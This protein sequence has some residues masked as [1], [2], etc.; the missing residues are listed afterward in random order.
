MEGWKRGRTRTFPRTGDQTIQLSSAW[1]MESS[2]PPGCPTSKPGSRHTSAITASHIF[3]EGIPPTIV[4]FKAQA[5]EKKSQK[6]RSWKTMDVK[7][8]HGSGDAG[9]LADSKARASLYN[10]YL[11]NRL[12]ASPHP[13][14]LPSPFL[15]HSLGAH[16]IYPPCPPP[17]P[18][19]P[20]IRIY[21]Q[22]ALIQNPTRALVMYSIQNPSKDSSC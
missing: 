17:P 20:P 18:F 7:L 3:S 21:Q 6:P 10:L 5:V 12:A 11:C 13:P 4:S 9:T 1:L 15:S 16:F 19:T 22:S 8:G 2:R 14:A